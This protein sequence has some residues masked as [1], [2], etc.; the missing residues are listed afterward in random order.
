M[1]IKFS[2]II[3]VAV[4]I[5]AGIYGLSKKGTYIDCN[6]DKTSYQN[7]QVAYMSDGISD[8]QIEALRN[9]DATA[10]Y[11][12]KVKCV[13]NL[14]FRPECASQKVKVEKV[15]KGD[16]IKKGETLSIIMISTIFTDQYKG[17][18]NDYHNY[19]IKNKEY[20]VF[21]DKQIKNYDDNDKVFIKGD[22]PMVAPY[23][24]YEDIINKP[25]GGKDNAMETTIK[26]SECQDD[27]FFLQSDDTI[28][29]FAEL[30]KELL[31]KYK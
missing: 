3:T 12:L 6:K 14:F 9:V 21:L 10:N 30:K 5:A 2:A 11:I 20:L 29:K 19:L 4:V 16:N 24:C 27:E 26:Y 23:F 18:N 15:F 1:K 7:F 17:F 28:K 22:I 31:L 13:D 25:H 8:D